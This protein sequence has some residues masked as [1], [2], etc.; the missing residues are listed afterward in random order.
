[1]IS[2]TGSSIISGRTI[3]RGRLKSSIRTR[4]RWKVC[5]SASCI[6]SKSAS[7]RNP[8]SQLKPTLKDYE[9]I[10]GSQ[11]MNEIRLLAAQL[12]GKRILN[13][14]S[15][16]VGGGVAEILNRMIPLFQELGVDARWDV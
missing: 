13:V 11:V 9:P 6:T 10:V 16:A 14:N 2:R 12:K 7:R 1:M 5:G 8:M 4:R 3:S 15:T